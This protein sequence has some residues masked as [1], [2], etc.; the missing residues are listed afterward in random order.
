LER[1]ETVPYNIILLVWIKI[2][3]LINNSR[4]PYRDNILKSIIFNFVIKA[5]FSGK[6]ATTV[7]YLE[8][9]TRPENLEI[10]E[11]ENT[12]IIR[13]TKPPVHFYRYL[14]NTVGE[15]WLWFERRKLSDEELMKDIHQDS[16]RIYVLYV[17]G[18]P[19]GYSELDF[20]DDNTK[21]VYFGLMPEFIGKGYGKYFLNW[22][23]N[24]AWSVNK[25]PLLVNTCTL[26]APNALEIYKKSG[27]K[28]YA[29]ENKEFNM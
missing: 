24:E 1:F 16:I 18:V 26:D 21:L 4:L 19:A 6:I 9:D 3:Y 2:I 15:Q 22:T 13:I 23:I 29:T 12:G 5:M 10:K 11:P 20:G 27:F 14:Y 28:V 17:S 8:M 25:G 7:S